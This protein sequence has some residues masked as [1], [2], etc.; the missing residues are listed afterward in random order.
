MVSLG[1]HASLGRTPESRGVVYGDLDLAL[2]L[3]TS[4]EPAEL[5]RSKYREDGHVTRDEDQRQVEITVD[6]T[7]R[8]RRAA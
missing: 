8:F 7:S 4:H 3:V 1:R 6:D 5:E 2:V